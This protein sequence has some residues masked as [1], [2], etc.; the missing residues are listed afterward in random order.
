MNIEIIGSIQKYYSIANKI[1]GEDGNDLLHHVLI[2]F[3]NKRKLTGDD[4]FFYFNKIL[5]NEYY[6]KKSTFH[7]LHTITAISEPIE[8]YSSIYDHEQLHDILNQ[9]PNK[10]AVEIFKRCY[11]DSNV[12]TVAKELNVS[13]MTIYRNYIK[14]VKEEIKKHYVQS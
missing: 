5:R 2:N 6:N 9:I 14:F 8:Y 10:K 11:F 13:K 12:Q 3:K 1:A 4:L 7:K